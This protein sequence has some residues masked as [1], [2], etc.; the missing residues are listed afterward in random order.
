M[1][2]RSSEAQTLPIADS[3]KAWIRPYHQLGECDF[4]TFLLYFVVSLFS[5]TLLIQSTVVLLSIGW[6]FEFSLCHSLTHIET[7]HEMCCCVRIWVTEEGGLSED[8][9]KQFWEQGFV[10]KK[11]LFEPSELQ[12]VIRSVEIHTTILRIRFLMKFTQLL[13]HF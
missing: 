5:C 13:L 1:A 12:D 11:N 2:T 6:W 10:L 8:E 4:F 9:F 3:I 7:K